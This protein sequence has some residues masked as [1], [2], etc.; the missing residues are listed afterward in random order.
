MRDHR[1]EEKEMTVYQDFLALKHHV[2]EIHDFREL[3]YGSAEEHGTLPAFILREK[4]IPYDAFQRDYRGLCTALLNR[5]YHGKRIA[6][7]GANSY[8]WILSYLAAGSI[9]VVVP[10]DKELSAEDQWNFIREAACS[11]IMADGAFLDALEKAAKTSDETGCAADDLTSFCLEETS[12]VR[13]DRTVFD[14]A[15]EGNALYEAG[16]DEFETLDLEPEALHILIFT[17]G[18]TGNAKGVCLSQK[19]ICTNIKSI[20]EMVRVDPSRHALS[21]LP[22]H[23]TY[24][25]TIGHLLLL[26]AGGCIS[27][28][29]GLRYVGKN[30]TEYRPSVIIAVPLLLEFMVRNIE[31]SIRKGLPSIYTKTPGLSLPELLDSLPAI[32]K[33]IVLRK[34]RKSL[35]GRLKLLI[36]GAAA[37][38]PEVI[39]AFAALGIT[40]YQ[41]YGLTECAPLLAGNNDFYQNV[42]AVGLPI[43]GVEIK[44]ENPN[45]EGIGEIVAKGDNIMLEYYQDPDGTAEAM[46]DGYFHT[47]DLGRFDPEGFLYITG[48][49]KNVIVTRNGKNIYPEEL[50]TRLME[51]ELIEEVVVIGVPSTKKDDIVAK[52]KIFPNFELIE[53]ITNQKP[54]S[55]ARLAEIV[56]MAV[57]QVNDKLPVYK[58]IVE[59][60]IVH[61]AFE[62]TTTKKIKRF[63]SNV[64]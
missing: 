58:R 45:E 29:D 47:G 37:V 46:R 24:E 59:V 39:E 48:R 27:Y 49:W 34:V 43:H 26:S 3:V 35:G 28:C 12:K 60:E 57:E 36:V 63:G 32:L 7:I 25:S 13:Y 42:E 33:K 15:W 31:K 6:V 30:L 9:G 23:H 62:K 40:T 20:A 2:R 1:M 54:A 22:L 19:N 11:A 4:E 10:I 14:L 50:E 18:T 53:G 8:G 52:A 17:S 5:G 61:E 16:Q 64:K 38:R 55:D 41:G 44:I 56:K 21:V 51:E